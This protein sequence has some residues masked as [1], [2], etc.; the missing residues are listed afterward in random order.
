MTPLI[1]FERKA[2]KQADSQSKTKRATS[3]RT[4]NTTKQPHAVTP[5]LTPVA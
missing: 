1:A 4:N 5:P 3:E 2:S